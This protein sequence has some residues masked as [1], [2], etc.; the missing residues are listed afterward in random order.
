M[1]ML[2]ILFVVIGSLF[3]LWM[4]YESIRTQQPFT[5]KQR[6]KPDQPIEY[7]LKIIN[8]SFP[9]IANPFQRFCNEMIGF[10]RKLC[11]S[12]SNVND[13]LNIGKPL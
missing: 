1:N 9:N 11:F 12:F 7:N 3:F 6:G 5:N 2:D 10:L 13:F 8:V 4:F